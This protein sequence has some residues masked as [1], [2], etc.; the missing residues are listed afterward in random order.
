MI[1]KQ[2]LTTI[3][4]SKL[5]LEIIHNNENF[6]YK[7]ENGSQFCGKM[8][9]TGDTKV[10]NTQLQKYNIQGISCYDNFTVERSISLNEHKFHANIE[11]QC[12]LIIKRKKLQN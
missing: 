5:K 9:P 11:T 1:S 10:V 3:I 7:N 8:V 12:F 4:I 6:C 2:T